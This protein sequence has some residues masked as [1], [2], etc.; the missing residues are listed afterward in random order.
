MVCGVRFAMDAERDLKLNEA[1]GIGATSVRFC[2]VGCTLG[3]LSNDTGKNKG[4]ESHTRQQPVSGAARRF[5]RC[6]QT[7]R[8]AHRS[9][10]GKA[11][12][13]RRENSSEV[14]AGYVRHAEQQ[15]VGGTSIAYAAL[16]RTRLLKSL[17]PT[18]TVGRVGAGQIVPGIY[19]CGRVDE[20]IVRSI[21]W[22]G[23]LR[24]ARCQRVRS[25]ITST[26]SKPT[27]GLRT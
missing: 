9:A 24:T 10:N 17:A 25:F 19:W 22:C 4:S 27:T 8:H 18:T 5:S 3:K 6:A 13:Q 15:L 20:H 2:G 7:P 14:I 21:S 12:L 16:N 11:I 26:V 1:A 23:K